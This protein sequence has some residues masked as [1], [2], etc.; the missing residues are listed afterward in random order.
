MGQVVVLK[1]Y[2][3]TEE[4]NGTIGLNIDDD[5]GWKETFGTVM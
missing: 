4:A 1:L 5:N 2:T 3:L